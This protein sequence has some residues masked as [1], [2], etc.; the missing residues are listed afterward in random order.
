MDVGCLSAV[1]SITVVTSVL[2]GRVQV[3][4]LLGMCHMAI[5]LHILF[6]EPLYVWTLARYLWSFAGRSI[7]DKTVAGRVDPGK[8]NHS[9]ACIEL[10]LHP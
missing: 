7:K 6:K 3:F 5:L 9:H 1:M 2:S 4:E 10:G 8:G